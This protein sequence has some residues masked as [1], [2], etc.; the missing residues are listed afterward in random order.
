MTTE[1]DE[2]ALTQVT[3][4]RCGRSGTHPGQLL[5]WTRQRDRRRGETWLCTTCTREA[6]SSIEA[7]L[8][9]LY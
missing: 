9:D 3:C 7:G 8:D 6:I 5:G 4:Q 2:T 1:V